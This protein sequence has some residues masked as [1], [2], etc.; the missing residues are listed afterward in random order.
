MSKKQAVVSFLKKNAFYLILAV[1]LTVIAIVGAVVLLNQNNSAPTFKKDS[2]SVSSSGFHSGV[3]SNSGSTSNS[4]SNGN[5]TS[6]SQNPVPTIITFTMPVENGIIS[7]EYTDNTV[8][9]NPTLGV[10]SAHLAIDITG[11]E[12]ARVLCA[13]SGVVESIDTSYLQG[14]VVTINHGDGLKTVY[15]SLEVDENLY[16]G[17]TLNAGDEIGV[18][19]TTNRQEYKEGAHLHFETIK[20]DVKVDPTDYL[21][22]EEDK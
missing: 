13:Y 12:G 14:T 5:S 7:K 1:V 4:T 19:S 15:S 22:I 8:V 6:S 10:Y 9:F 21:V 18:I 3:T 11:A 17:Q 16:V 2:S 20:N